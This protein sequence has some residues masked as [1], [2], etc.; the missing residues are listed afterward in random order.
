VIWQEFA[1]LPVDRDLKN[2]LM[3]AVFLFQSA[4]FGKSGASV[5]CAPKVLAQARHQFHEITGNV[6]AV[7]LSAQDVIPTVFDCAV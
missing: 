3:Q 5:V 2:I 1:T 4:V 6:S 7:E